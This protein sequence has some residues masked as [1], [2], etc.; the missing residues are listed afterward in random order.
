M[1]RNHSTIIKKKDLLA[2][3]EIYLLLIINHQISIN[4]KVID[5]GDIPIEVEKAKDI[6]SDYFIKIAKINTS[7]FIVDTMKNKIPLIISQQPK[8]FFN[9]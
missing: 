5:E 4:W 7:Q 2:E 1:T 8:L 3:R 9:L 6:N